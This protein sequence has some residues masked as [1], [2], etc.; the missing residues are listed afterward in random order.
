VDASRSQ[1]LD[2]ALRPGQR[3]TGF[4]PARTNSRTLPF[5]RMLSRATSFSVK[6]HIR[7]S[8]IA[9]W[10]GQTLAVASFTA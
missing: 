4:V 9:N 7:R 6:F 2:D 1:T 10:L 5:W 8:R 3:P